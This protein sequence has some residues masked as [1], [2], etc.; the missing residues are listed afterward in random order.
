[1]RINTPTP[2]AVN[3][4]AP[5]LYR[6]CEVLHT[7]TLPRARYELEGTDSAAWLALAVAYSPSSIE[8]RCQYLLRLQEG[9]RQLVWLE[10]GN[11]AW[12]FHSWA[13]AEDAS[14]GIVA[15]DD[16]APSEDVLESTQLSDVAEVLRELGSRVRKLGLAV[17]DQELWPG[18]DWETPPGAPSVR[19]RHRTGSGRP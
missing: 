16:R 2:P 14:W 4:D 12:G 1:M 6:V 9:L 19:C 13:E 10:L 15:D 7:T 3:E 17:L 11:P 8:R 18:T 5:V